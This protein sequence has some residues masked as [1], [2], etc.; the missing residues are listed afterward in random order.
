M[1]ESHG[2]RNPWRPLYETYGVALW[3][4][5]AGLAWLSAPWWDL[6][7]RSSL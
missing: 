4:A 1:N 2:Y 7:R 6:T 5:A 3:G